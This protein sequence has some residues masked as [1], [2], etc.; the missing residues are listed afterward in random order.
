MSFPLS[1][2]LCRFASQKVSQLAFSHFFST[3]YF[4]GESFFLIGELHY[5]SENIGEIMR[6]DRIVNTP[7][8][9]IFAFPY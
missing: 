6:G 9:V 5:K 2:I 7:Y 3:Y 1:T 4:I 8:E